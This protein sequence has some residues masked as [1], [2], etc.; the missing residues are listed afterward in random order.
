MKGRGIVDFSVTKTT[1]S[2][3]LAQ[4][5]EEMQAESPDNLWGSGVLWARS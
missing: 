3:P 5:V 4:E 2:I 1:E